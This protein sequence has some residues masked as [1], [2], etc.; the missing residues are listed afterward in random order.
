[1]SASNLCAE[2][3]STS[4]ALKT[5][6]FS[7]SALIGAGCGASR[8]R[9]QR[10]HGSRSQGPLATLPGIR[11]GKC[12]AAWATFLSHAPSWDRNTAR[13][14]VR[15]QAA[16]VQQEKR[17]VPPSIWDQSIVHTASN[18][19]IHAESAC[20]DSLKQKG[21]RVLVQDLRK[22]FD[23]GRSE[24]VAADGINVDIPPGTITALLGPSGSGKTTL[25]RMIAGLDQPDSGKIFFDD[26]DATNLP[27][28]DRHI[29]FVF[30][31]FALFNHM[32]VG[33]NIRFGMKMRKLNVD[34]AARTKEL[35]EM[36]ELSDFEN[37]WPQAMSGGQRQRV[38]LVR[39]LAS[40]PRLL[41]LDEPFG[42][43]DPRI[44][45][46][47][48]RELRSLIRRIGITAIFVTHDQEEAWEISDYVAVF[49]KGKVQQ[50]APP[51]EIENHPANPFVLNF[52][53]DVNKIPSDC[54]FARR[55]GIFTKK[56][57]VMF[58]PTRVEVVQELPPIDG[59]LYAPATV[60]DRSDSGFN[61]KYVL[62][63]DDGVSFERHLIG[64]RARIKKAPVLYAEERVYVRVDKNELMPFGPEDLDVGI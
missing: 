61:T 31:S 24:F 28:Q 15:A 36:I 34:P 49:N 57:F 6:A 1:M 59:P 18:G 53:G 43:L 37:R 48:R 12:K 7:Q 11:I 26:E 60:V 56:P 55:M 14:G 47:L 33:E 9:I 4:F 46:E 19:H 27:V 58:R 38:A 17:S 3:P 63:F 32:T 13:P 16:S 52:I 62:R 5:E 20:L 21:V 23:D 10:A 35:L 22:T 25:L 8:R 40:E 54:E 29:G 41:L 45:G 51:S 64:E 42:A 2:A 30:Q 39:A 44:R 50:I